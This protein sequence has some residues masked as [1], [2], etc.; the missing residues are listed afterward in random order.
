M[1]A[2]TLKLSIMLELGRSS[3]VFGR[4]SNVFEFF[5]KRFRMFSV[6]QNFSSHL[7]FFKFLRRSRGPAVAA[8]K[9]VAAE[10]PA[11]AAAAA[12]IQLN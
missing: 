4:V 5:F 7:P 11:A 12:K 3:D 10:A 8:A 1:L 9:A 6:V 2:E